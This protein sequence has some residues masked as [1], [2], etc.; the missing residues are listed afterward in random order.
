MSGPIT[1]GVG[2]WVC[3][4]PSVSCGCGHGRRLIVGER[5]R[6]CDRIGAGDDAGC[7]SSG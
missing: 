4:R 2:A 3:A 1:S 5:G 7:C 6:V